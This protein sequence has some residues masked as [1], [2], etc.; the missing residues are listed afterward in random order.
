MPATKLSGDLHNFRILMS[1]LTI[2]QPKGSHPFFAEV[3]FQP[4]DLFLFFRL[5]FL[6]RRLRSTAEAL[7][8]YF[9][10]D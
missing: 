6:H 1:S 10:S 2:S 8:C 7:V 9:E 5:H 4:G 3:L